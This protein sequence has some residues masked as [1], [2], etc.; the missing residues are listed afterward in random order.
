MIPF[1]KDNQRAYTLLL[2]IEIVLRECIS[3]AY[4]SEFGVQWQKRI[5]GDLLLKIKKSQTD[6]WKPYFNF[7]KLG[8]LYYLTFAELVPILKLKT[9]L[10]FMS[11]LGGD[12][13]LRQLENL[14]APRNAI[15]HSRPVSSVGLMAVEALYAQLETAL[16]IEEFA[17]LLS[18]PDAGLAQDNAANVLI[19]ALQEVVRCMPK[20]PP[21]FTI[22]EEYKTSTVQYWWK[23]DSLAGFN[24]LTVEIAMTII[25]EYNNLPVGVGCAGIRHGFIEQRNMGSVVQQAIVELEKVKL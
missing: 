25:S 22:P 14:F 7:M 23:D 10:V 1:E 15:C 6:E 3:R 2:R 11:K 18:K 20:L 24:R 5:P 4:Q 19:P 13:F 17:R 21:S 9:C 12:G 16:S 8:P